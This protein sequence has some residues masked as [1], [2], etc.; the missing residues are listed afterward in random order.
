[1][2]RVFGVIVF[3]LGLGLTGWIAYNVLIERL[4]EAQGRNP[5]PGMI[6]AT[7][8]LYV[9]YKWMMGRQAG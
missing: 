9:G 4:P 2:R 7:A 1:M 5:L 8:F 3:L 6:T